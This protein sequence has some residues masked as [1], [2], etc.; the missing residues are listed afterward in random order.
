MTEVARSNI[1]RN[2]IIKMRE[3]G[4]LFTSQKCF[5][6]RRNLR[7]FAFSIN[8]IRRKTREGGGM[9]TT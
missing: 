4:W 7:L 3:E 9:K 2:K 6:K 8:K 1:K 5:K